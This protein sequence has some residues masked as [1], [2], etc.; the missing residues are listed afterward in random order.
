MTRSVSKPESVETYDFFY[1]HIQVPYQ[2]KRKVVAAGKPR[3][4][5]IKVSPDSLVTVTAPEDAETSNIHDAVMKRAKWIYDS[6]QTFCA[7]QMHVQ[8]RRYVSGEVQFYLG[9]RYV[10]K[11]V[12]N[13]NTTPQVRMERGQLQVMLPKYH[14]ANAAQIRALL[15]QWYRTRAHHIF[16]SRLEQLLPQA[17]WVDAMPPFRIQAMAKQWGSCS[18]Q[19]TLILNPHLVK[20][21]RDCIDYVIMHELCHIKEHNHS[22]RFYRLLEQ[23]MPEW[24]QTKQALDGL[25]ELLLN[26]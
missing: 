8:P 26:E 21:P 17:T 18:K 3:K 24:K 19:G 7:Q 13:T 22:E 23:Q 16:K 15:R 6:L 2:V 5:S 10:L 1:G 11:V 14:T 12:K 9:R 20:A 4:I 25:A